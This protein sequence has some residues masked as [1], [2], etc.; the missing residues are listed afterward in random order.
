ME[1]LQ[2]IANDISQATGI[3]APCEA[4][5]AVGGGC[6]NRAIL[7]RHANRSYFVKLNDADKLDMFAAEAEGL[8]ALEGEHGL[9]IPA[10]VCWGV[11]ANNAWLVMEHLEF[12]GPR[13]P[14]ELGAGLAVMHRMLGKTY[15]WHRDNTIGSTPQLNTPAGN[16]M[17]FWRDRRLG[18]QLQL[19]RSNGASASLTAQGDRL[20]DQL[21]ALL[22]EHQPV[23]SVLHGDLWA[24]NHAYTAD[25][26]PAIF[27]PAVYFGDRETDL[28]MT[29]LFGGFGQDFHAAYREAWPLESGYAMRR[30]LYNLY[31]VLN[32]FNL[33]GGG[34]HNQALAM[35]GALLAET[36]C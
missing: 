22:G 19:A 3:T 2:N 36:R 8:R 18:Y 25:G 29:E 12:G 32:H 20:L 24:G 28:A 10:P 11:D 9:C 13:H 16:W 14:G 27:D 34:Y 33:F 35:M 4:V 1:N 6:I 7:V 21:P 5:G 26:R 31:H 30:T 15:G 17:Q 23:A